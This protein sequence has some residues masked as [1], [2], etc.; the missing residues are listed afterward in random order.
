MV[1]GAGISQEVTDECNGFWNAYVKAI[2]VEGGLAVNVSGILC[3]EG[4]WANRKS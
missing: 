3:S 2:K 4:C 1:T